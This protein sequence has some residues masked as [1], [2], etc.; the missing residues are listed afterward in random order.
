MALGLSTL[1]TDGTTSVTSRQNTVTANAAAG[2]ANLIGIYG[3]ASLPTAVTDSQGNT[4]TQQVSQSSAV[5]IWMAVIATG[6]NLVS[7]T[8]WI[9]VDWGATSQ[10]R[11]SI[12][13]TVTSGFG[14]TPT[15][16][17]TNSGTATSQS[18]FPAASLTTTVAAELLVCFEAYSVASVGP[19]TMTAATSFTKLTDGTASAGSGTNSRIGCEYQAVASTGTYSTS[20]SGLWTA[21]CNSVF[22]VAISLYAAS[23]T[24]DQDKIRTGY[25]R[26]QCSK[27]ATTQATQW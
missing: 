3:N 27:P 7:G 24:Y 21:S 18:G 1:F 2:Q 10:A 8:D 25:S 4:Y 23:L 5:S 16:D 9:K 26:T 12:A 17:V 6:K 19:Q 13:A 15:K 14:G 11:V 20:A 22:A